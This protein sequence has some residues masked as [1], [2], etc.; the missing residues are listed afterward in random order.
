MR[1]PADPE[2]S[3][4]DDQTLPEDVVQAGLALSD[5]FKFIS[6]YR[7]RGHQIGRKIGDMLEV[8]TLAAI[9]HDSELSSRLVIEPYIE[10]AS[11]A[12]HKVEFAIYDG[13]ESDLRVVLGNEADLL[14]D[15]NGATVRKKPAGRNR[16]IG[17]RH[18]KRLRAFIECKKVG[19]EQ[20]VNSNFKK[21]ESKGRDAARFL[22]Y[23]APFAM[24]FQKRPLTF[25]FSKSSSG[26][27]IALEWGAELG[28]TSSKA[29]AIR[30]DVISGS[31]FMFGSNV[32]GVP[33]LL[34]NSSDLS[35]VSGSIQRCKI[36][37]IREV[38]RDGVFCLLNDCLPGPQTPEKAKQ[39]SFVALDVRKLRFG[40]FDKRTDEQDCVSILVLTEFAHWE[41]KSQN[42]V[43]MS[44]DYNLVVDDELLE[45][46]IK[47]YSAEFND[48]MWDKISKEFFERDHRVRQIA[49]KL[50]S[51]KK[52]K[53]FRDI[54]DGK[55][56][57]ICWRDGRVQVV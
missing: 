2:P 6:G 40:T 49:E 21:V 24:K 31:R 18:N 44:I 54:A 56:K 41:P 57:N 37:E 5:I 36:L 34:G 47:A 17:A 9:R 39:A 46:A 42:M 29:M 43:K 1:R 4:A 14:D 15:E 10:G 35:T 22:L 25:Q 11:T 23:S 32:D 45:E 30:E 51:L 3:S 55:L 13:P 28:S 26:T 16:I 38:T 12:K 27:R 8:L 53:I 19:V 52:G 33:F 7:Q 48:D 20:T 50:I